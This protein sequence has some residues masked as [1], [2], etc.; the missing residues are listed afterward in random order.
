MDGGKMSKSLGNLYTLADLHARGVEPAAFRLFCYSASYRS[1][2][3]FTWDALEA[4]Q[5]SLENLRKEYQTQQVGSEDIVSCKQDFLN[6]LAHD[7]NTSAALG[8]MWSTLRQPLSTAAR[9]AFLDYIDTIFSLG[10]AE[11]PAAREIPA[12]ILAL[13]SERDQARAN[14]DW[15]TSDKLRD[16]IQSAGFQVNDTPAGTKIS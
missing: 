15:A 13:A 1:K 7:L 14:K 6:T 2:L 12:D 8:V 9:Q 4:A 3:N 5:T 16:Q 11:A 10:I